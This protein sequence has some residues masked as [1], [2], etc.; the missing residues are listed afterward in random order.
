MAVL[1]QWLQK[2][3]FIYCPEK[4][5]HYKQRKVRGEGTRKD[6]GFGVK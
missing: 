2:K 6:E 3:N 4:V 1:R 5:D